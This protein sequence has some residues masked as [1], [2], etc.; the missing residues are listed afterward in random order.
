MI[1]EI[2][3]SQEWDYII[4]GLDTLA[5]A[6]AEKSASK[7]LTEEIIKRSEEKK[8]SLGRELT[9]AEDFEL[10][11]NIDSLVDKTR[12]HV[13]EKIENYAIAAAK[14]IKLKRWITSLKDQKEIDTFLKDI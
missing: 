10:A 5:K 8:K 3:T 4:Q 1:P 7:L 12:E 9:E 14:F 2:P 6:E 13:R 11:F